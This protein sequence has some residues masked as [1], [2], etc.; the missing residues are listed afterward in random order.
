MNTTLYYPFSNSLD[1][2]LDLIDSSLDPLFAQLHFLSLSIEAHRCKALIPCE[3]C[4][5]EIINNSIILSSGAFSINKQTITTLS[6]QWKEAESQLKITIQTSQGSTTEI[7]APAKQSKKFW[8]IVASLD[9]GNPSNI[10]TIDPSKHVCPCCKK[11]E[12]AIEQATV[13]HP[14]S[15]ILADLF[16]S[17]QIIQYKLLN[18]SDY[19]HLIINPLSSHFEKGKGMFMGS[20]GE[21][22]EM[23][24]ASTHGVHIH[25]QIIDHENYSIFKIFNSFGANFLEFSVQGA[26]QLKKWSSM[27]DTIHSYKRVYS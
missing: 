17:N 3:K 5:L 6:I 1:S 16:R 9:T 19:A 7:T 15:L 18:G 10:K 8:D 20:G 4:S 26:C 24:I 22:L 25:H 2:Q 21:E 23:S 27:L 14:V 11:R 12:Q 13:Q